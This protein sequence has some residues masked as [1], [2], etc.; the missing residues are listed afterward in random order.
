MRLERYLVEAGMP[1]GTF[2]SER[3]MQYILLGALFHSEIIHPASSRGIGLQVTRFFS[4][5]LAAL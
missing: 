3:K 1:G 2:E 4:E 5:L